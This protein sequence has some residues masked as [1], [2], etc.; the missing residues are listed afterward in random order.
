MLL[1]LVLKSSSLLQ[2]N[3]NKDL[4]KIKLIVL[5]V[6]GTLTDG[7]VYIDSNGVET[8]KFNI[9]D[10]AGIVLAEKAG[11]EFMILTGRKSYCVEKRA[12]E[13][14][15][16]YVFQGIM[17]KLKY[18]NNFLQEHNLSPEQVAYMGD[19]VND[20]ECMQYV[21]FTACPADAVKKVCEYVDFVSQFNGGC[22]AVRE[23]CDMIKDT[24][25]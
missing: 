3:M 2:V 11:I 10:G 14:K 5:D 19:D 16:K 24:I 13:L 22:G 12:E 23:I 8:K 15:I 1:L 17:D 20:L 25:K 4:S 21:G 6:D 7:G 9:K 18:L